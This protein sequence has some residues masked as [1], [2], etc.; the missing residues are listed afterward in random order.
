[1][2]C[3]AVLPLGS[4]IDLL[5]THDPDKAEQEEEEMQIYEKYDHMLHGGSRT[6]RCV[7]VCV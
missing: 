1:M 2:C 3:V 6:K 7:C 4:S 5:S